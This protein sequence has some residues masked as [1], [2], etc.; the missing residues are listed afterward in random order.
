MRAQKFVGLQGRAASVRCPHQPLW[1]VPHSS[2][3]RSHTGNSQP[4]RERRREELRTRHQHFV[5]L[6]RGYA[7]PCRSNDTEMTRGATRASTS[8]LSCDAHRRHRDR[9]GA[10][11]ARYAHSQSRIRQEHVN[12]ALSWASPT[13]QQS[14]FSRPRCTFREVLAKAAGAAV[15]WRRCRARR[16]PADRAVRSRTSPATAARRLTTSRTRSASG[17]VKRGPGA[18][19]RRRK[20]PATLDATPPR[21][22]AQ[23][24]RPS[25]AP[26]EALPPCHLAPV[27]HWVKLLATKRLARRP[28]RLQT[29]LNERPAARRR[30]C[31]RPAL[32]AGACTE[33]FA[34]AACSSTPGHTT[35]SWMV[36]WWRVR[37]SV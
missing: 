32:A 7:F 11:D 17:P 36:G 18:Q 13:S 24:P 19:T 34:H 33:S 16:N 22:R 9:L 25:C 35:R 23:F 5:P 28:G 26:A 20:G 31:R 2:R 8:S 37:S 1:K 3:G 29:S 6:T 4:R 14:R 12:G 27:D 30:R 15:R 21:S 10:T